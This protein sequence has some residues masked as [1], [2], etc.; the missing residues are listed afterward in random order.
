MAYCCFLRLS[1]NDVV[2]DGYNHISFLHAIFKATYW[3][4]LWSLLLK[5]V[6]GEEVH[7]KCRIL[8]KQ[9]MEFFS[10]FGWNFL[11]N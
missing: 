1:M 11:K 9:V 5:K 3:A 8:E 2:F 4:R 6:E 7:V 10:S